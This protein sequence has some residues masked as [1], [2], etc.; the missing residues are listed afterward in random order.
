[1]IH[2]PEANDRI[3]YQVSGPT[4]VETGSSSQK[5]SRNLADLEKEFESESV[6]QNEGEAANYGI[7]FDDSEYDYM[8]HLRDLGTNSGNVH[9]VEAA[10]TKGKG[11]GKAVKLEDALRGVSLDDSLSELAAKSVYESEHA[12]TYARSSASSYLRKPTYQDQ[13][14]VPDA[15]AGL[16]PDM[17]PRLREVLEALDDEAYV[18]DDTRDVFGELTQSA[19]EIEPGEWE[20]TL[21]DNVDDGGDSDA[22]EKAP[23]QQSTA[24][25]G[26]SSDSDDETGGVSI[27]GEDPVT[28]PDHDKPGP[29]TAPE[30]GEWLKEFAKYKKDA[31]AVKPPAAVAEN[32][33]E[34][35]TAASTL[36]TIGGTPL[37]Q[38]KR[39]GA[40][41]NPSAY[42]MT[43]SSLVRTEGL[44]LLDDRF[45]RIEALYSVD[46]E[47]TEYDADGASMISGVTGLSEAPSLVSRGGQ[48]VPLRSDFDEVMDGFLAG[49]Q[50]R[51]SQAKRK[52]ARGKRGKN[53]NEAVGIKMLDEIRQGLGP[54]KIP[55]NVSSGT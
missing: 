15:I 30:N 3:L 8:Q 28:L 39:K 25:D 27:R 44:Q 43:S 42:S 36:F 6:R 47:G 32:V 40:L 50:D 49:W 11:K 13:Q 41:T 16:Q 19:Q 23:E 24:K 12:S 14:N 34:H 54:A 2:D 52:G 48:G 55:G 5:P 18:D 31:K 29:D 4:P 17:D 26:S 46:E 20:D 22:T 1:M 9:F 10:P 35:R 45:T 37:R 7:F 51:S 38:K 33:S 21:F 53:G